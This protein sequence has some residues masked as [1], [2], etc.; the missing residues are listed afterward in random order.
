MKPVKRNRQGLR[1]RKSIGGDG[2]R[3]WSESDD[4]ELRSLLAAGKRIQ[5][6]AK[7]LGRNTMSISNRLQHFKRQERLARQAGDNHASGIAEHAAAELPAAPDVAHLRQEAER[8]LRLATMAT[9]LVERNVLQRMA[10][11]LLRRVQ[12]AGVHR[13]P[14]SNDQPSLIA[15]NS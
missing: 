7:K 11:E 13:L 5:V 4:R 10:G 15:P 3:T 14:N 1:L 6:I 2:R 8:C 9:D 12:A